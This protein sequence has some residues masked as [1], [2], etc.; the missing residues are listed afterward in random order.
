M[1]HEILLFGGGNE[2]HEKKEEDENLLNLMF[3][4]ERESYL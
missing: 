2:W 4:D 1:T 3:E